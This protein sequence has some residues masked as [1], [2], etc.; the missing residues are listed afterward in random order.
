MK[1]TLIA[2]TLLAACGD[3]TE[4]FT[5]LDARREWISAGCDRFIRCGWSTYST[6]EEC[7]ET[8]L[9]DTAQYCDVMI[10]CD[11]KYPFEDALFECTDNYRELACDAGEALPCFPGE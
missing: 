6:V 8:V 5:Y 4:Q 11:K 9:A 10:E 3:N 7:T 2:L 1:R